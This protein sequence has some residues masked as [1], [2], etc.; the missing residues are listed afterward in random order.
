MLLDRLN[1]DEMDAKFRWWLLELTTAAAVAAA[2]GDR[3]T[4]DVT[5]LSQ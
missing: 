1:L 2:T 5:R 4:D 3:R